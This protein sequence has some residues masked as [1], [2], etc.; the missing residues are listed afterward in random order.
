MF[1]NVL[2]AP[3]LF[4]LPLLLR[5]S[6]CARVAVLVVMTCSLLR[7]RVTGG[8]DHGGLPGGESDHISVGHLRYEQVNNLG[9]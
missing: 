4:L 9:F 5:S 2:A 7:C 6:P 8:A 3:T 1:R